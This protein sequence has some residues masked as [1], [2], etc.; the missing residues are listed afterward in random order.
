MHVC[1]PTASA[2]RTDTGVVETRNTKWRRSHYCMTEVLY[3][4]ISNN[5]VPAH[6]IIKAPEYSLGVQLMTSTNSGYSATEEVL[7][8]KHI[9]SV[10]WLDAG[11]DD[12]SMKTSGRRGTSSLAR[13]HECY[14]LQNYSLQA[15]AN[16][17]LNTTHERLGTTSASVGKSSTQTFIYL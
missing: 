7:P 3:I 12:I 2:A 5:I 9:P 13:R 6:I 15:R 10:F 1:S 11:A 14:T 4:C 17:S 16:Y 8:V